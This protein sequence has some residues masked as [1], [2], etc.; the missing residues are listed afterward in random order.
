MHTFFRNIVLF[1][2]PLLLINLWFYSIVY[3][4]YL[5]EY[6]KVDLNYKTYFLAD[7]RGTPLLKEDSLHSFYNFSAPSDSYEDMDRK[8]NFLIENSAIER[9]VITVDD[10]TLSKYREQ[11]N[12]E[13][14]SIY[15]AN[16]SSFKEIYGLFKDKYLNRFFPLLS[17]KGR[18]I[19]ISYFSKKEKGKKTQEWSAISEVNRLERCKI[20]IAYQFPNDEKSEILNK[21]LQEIIKSC[22][23]NNI[24]LYGLKLPL[25]KEYIQAQGD[26]S[27]GAD[28]I[29]LDENIKFIDFTKEYWFQESF[30]FNED[31]LNKIGGADLTKRLLDTL[32]S[33]NF[34]KE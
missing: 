23:D 9:L 2:I 22:K 4:L 15:F 17:P 24:K 13:D 34:R 18:D 27:Y 25:A 33:S 32:N 7:S 20:R 1:I 5:Q 8:L 14:R 31:H 19:I 30:F 26:K 11:S 10:H 16:V 12:N 6:E 28:N 29:F 3:T 21:S